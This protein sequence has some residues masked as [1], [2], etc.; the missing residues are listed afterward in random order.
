[1]HV[2]IAHNPEIWGFIIVTNRILTRSSH[3]YRIWKRFF[4]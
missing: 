3:A 2:G 4:G 1:M